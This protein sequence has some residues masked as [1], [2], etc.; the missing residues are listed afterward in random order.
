MAKL[1][2]W[3]WGSSAITI[4]FGNYIYLFCCY[5]VCKRIT[6]LTVSLIHDQPYPSTIDKM[7][8]GMKLG[9]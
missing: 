3:K 4:V 1:E 5:L 7:D 6:I 8:M 9:W 2:D